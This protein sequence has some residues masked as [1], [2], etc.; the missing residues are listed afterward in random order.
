MKKVLKAIAGFFVSLFASAKKFEQFLVD[1]VDDAISIVGKIREAVN[2]P[3]IGS[4][5]FFLPERHKKVGGEMLAKSQEILD[6]VLQELQVSE[7]C[8]KKATVFERLQCFVNQ[9]RSMSPA[10]QEAAFHKFASLYAKHSS[11]QTLSTRH[12]DTAVQDRF[13]MLKENITV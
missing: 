6:R 3:I 9:V 1:H 11:G 10:M 5:L 12:Y 2:S 8:L 13:F 7:D 4:I